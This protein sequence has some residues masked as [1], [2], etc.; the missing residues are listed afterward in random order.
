MN[1]RKGLKEGFMSEEKLTKRF[2]AVAIKKGFIT[3]DQFVEAMAMQIE[4]DLEGTEPKHLGAILNTM[5]Y[6]TD[7]QI[8]EV[9]G[10]MG[11]FV[12]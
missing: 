6:M 10:A 8:S 12:K 5:E 2:G 1:Y 9:L 7:E 4:N 11:V 3:K